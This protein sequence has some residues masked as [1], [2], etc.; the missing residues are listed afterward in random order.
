MLFNDWSDPDITIVTRSKRVVL[1]SDGLDKAYFSP[2][3]SDSD[4]DESESGAP[5]MVYY[6]SLDNENL[7]KCFSDTLKGG[8]VAN[9]PGLMN[10]VAQG[11]CTWDDVLVV[12]ADPDPE[13]DVVKLF[14]VFDGH[15]GKYVAQYAATCMGNAIYQQLALQQKKKQKHAFVAAYDERSSAMCL[16]AARAKAKAV[17]R[18]EADVT[19]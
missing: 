7:V 19:P 4:S 12:A 15:G 17:A 8:D 1:A 11:C 10:Q 16:Y 6:N 18:R 9:V 2:D 14:G 5:D 13:L 3:D